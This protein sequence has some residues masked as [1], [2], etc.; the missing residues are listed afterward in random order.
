MILS[1]WEKRQ[2]EVSVDRFILS[3]EICRWMHLF[4]RLVNSS[5]L[6][7]FPPVQEFLEIFAEK[8]QCVWLS[9]WSWGSL[10]HGFPW[11]AAGFCKHLCTG[12]ASSPKPC[13]VAWSSHVSG[14]GQWVKL[15]PMNFYSN[16]SQLGGGNIL[17]W[18]DAS[19]VSVIVASWLHAASRELCWVH[20]EGRRLP[21]ISWDGAQPLL[22]SPPWFSLCIVFL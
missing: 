21:T 14:R 1:H 17:W 4:F 19:P 8:V 10:G 9:S 11:S 13:Q 2:L 7:L 6:I 20:A 12:S 16:W 18:S 22:L 5:E 15:I 3:N